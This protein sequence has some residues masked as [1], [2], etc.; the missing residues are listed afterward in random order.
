MTVDAPAS[1]TV[2]PPRSNPGHA[3]AGCEAIPRLADP[4]HPSLELEHDAPAN[5][6]FLNELVGW[7]RLE[8]T[9]KSLLPDSRDE[10]LRH[11]EGQGPEARP[12]WGAAA[13]AA[14][15]RCTSCQISRGSS[16]YTS[17]SGQ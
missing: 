8:S 16:Q 10:G 7:H 5:G 2:R 1:I 9:T 13:D 17:R 4:P 15:R 14:R 12:G 3:V 6:D 11:A